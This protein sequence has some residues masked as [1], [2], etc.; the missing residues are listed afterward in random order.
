MTFLLNY[1]IIFIRYLS[2]QLIAKDPVS[3]ILFAINI[4]MVAL[5]IKSPKIF[6][7]FPG[8]YS[9]RGAVFVVNVFL[10]AVPRTAAWISKNVKR[11]CE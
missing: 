3:P 4:I 2:V 8:E 9:R 11:H 5:Q 7:K 1:I 10:A 6:V